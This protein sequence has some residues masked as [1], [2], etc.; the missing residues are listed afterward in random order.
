MQPQLRNTL[1]AL[2]VYAMPRP[3]VILPF[4]KDKFDA[5]GRLIDAKIREHLTSFM[6]AFAEWAARF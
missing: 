6:A 4:C 5:D 1:Q 3:E 2:D